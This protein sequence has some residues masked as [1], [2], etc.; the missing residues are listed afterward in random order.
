MAPLANNPPLNI[1]IANGTCAGL[2]D[3][4]T[5][6][7][8]QNASLVQAATVLTLTQSTTVVALCC[9]PGAQP[10]DDAVAAYTIYN[11]V[12]TP[13]VVPAAGRYVNS[14]NV[15]ASC[16]TPDS[17]MTYT[18]GTPVAEV[19]TATVVGTIGASG[20]GNATVVVTAAALAESPMTYSVAVTDNE[21]A[22]A[23]AAAMAAT[24]NADSN[25]T[26]LYTVVASGAQIILTER[27]LTGNDPTLNISIANG[28]CSGL[29]NEPSST[30]TTVG[31]DSVPQG[32]ST[33]MPMPPAVLTLA[34]PT[35]LNV[36]AFAPNMNPSPV[37]SNFYDIICGPR[38]PRSRRVPISGRRR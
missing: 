6:T 24:L 22:S 37:V 1:S 28:T 32:N 30:I 19:V 38:P 11:P 33:V 2:I 5:S 25:L 26:A 7:I 20:A 12:A 3:V 31:F 29:S 21:S 13:I 17:Y 16:T 15:S 10:S 4:P 9:S 36:G 18:T 27:T 35:T 8:T 34:Q 23:V 14:V